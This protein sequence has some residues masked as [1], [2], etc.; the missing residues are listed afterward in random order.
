MTFN[1]YFHLIFLIENDL[2]LKVESIFINP[3]CCWAKGRLI[4]CWTTTYKSKS[5]TLIPIVKIIQSL[6][7]VQ[8]D[9]YATSRGPGNW[10][11]ASLSLFSFPKSSA[12]R[13]LLPPWPKS[14]AGRRQRKGFPIRKVSDWDLTTNLGLVGRGYWPFYSKFLRTLTKHFSTLLP[15]LLGSPCQHPLLPSPTPVDKHP[16]STQLTDWFQPL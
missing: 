9:N 13:V 1:M 5:S 10:L 11:R 12:K 15:S 4:N 3:V 16:A 2:H 14:S 6:E 7:Q 8:K